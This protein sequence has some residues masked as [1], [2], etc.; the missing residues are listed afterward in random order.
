MQESTEAVQMAPSPRCKSKISRR[1]I[2][3]QE[4]AQRNSHLT[5]VDV[6]LKER[7]RDE[8]LGQS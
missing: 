4:L 5:K 2:L 8:S 1:E 6:Y 3:L 7:T